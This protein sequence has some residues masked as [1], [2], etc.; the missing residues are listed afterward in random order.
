[1]IR[2]SQLRNIPVILGEHQIG[3]VQSMLLDQMRKRVCAFVVSGGMR[4]KK[5]VSAQHICVLGEDF[6]MVDGWCRYRR[7]DKQQI[8]MFVRDTSGLLVGRVT[9]YAIDKR[10]LEVIAVEVLSGYLPHSWQAKSWMYEYCFSADSDELCTP[11]IIHNQ[12]NFSEEEF[13]ACGRPR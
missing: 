3:I 7:N 4:G 8:E 10:T 6:I 12:P 9:D 11:S 2:M 5:I 13:K 1:M